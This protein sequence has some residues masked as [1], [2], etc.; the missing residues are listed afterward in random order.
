MAL[1][2]GDQGIEIYE[3][4]QPLSHEVVLKKRRYS[5]FYGT[6]LDLILRSTAWRR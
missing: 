5:A 3:E 4:L 1:V 6:E 2:D